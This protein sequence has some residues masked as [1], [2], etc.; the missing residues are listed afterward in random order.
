MKRLFDTMENKEI[1]IN[2]LAIDSFQI[3]L[4]FL[5]EKDV[6]SFLKS[7][8][9]CKKWNKMIMELIKKHSQMSLQDCFY[10]GNIIGIVNHIMKLKQVGKLMDEMIYDLIYLNHYAKL[11][12]FNFITRF[13]CNLDD[14]FSFAL[15][16]NYTE[17]DLF[18]FYF[19][20]NGD[21]F[22]EKMEELN[23]N[24]IIELHKRFKEDTENIGK[25]KRISSWKNYTKTIKSSKIIDQSFIIKN[26]SSLSFSNPLLEEEEIWE[27][28]LPFLH[29]NGLLTKQKIIEWFNKWSKE[30]T[31]EDNSNIKDSN[32]TENFPEMATFNYHDRELRQ[33]EVK[34]ITL[35]SSLDEGYVEDLNIKAIVKDYIYIPIIYKKYESLINNMILEIS[36][37]ED[38][39]R[40]DKFTNIDIILNLQI[41]TNKIQGLLDWFNIFDT[42]ILWQYKE[43]LYDSE[44]IFPFNRWNKNVRRFI[45]LCDNT[46]FIDK[47]FFIDIV[48]YRLHK[49]MILILQKRTIPFLKQNEYNIDETLF[50]KM[51]LEGSLKDEILDEIFV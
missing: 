9:V 50:L 29:L 37:L 30:N 14:I 6:F 39:I 10:Y 15:S 8:I 4:K 7:R 34:I 3:I 12:N 20:M 27:S 48:E 42:D 49:L 32:I 16:F 40:R 11:V 22:I 13:F 24:S 5:C 35:L 28:V 19:H 26:F 47:T 45:E 21:K 33:I 41:K 2:H 36:T 17:T 18:R 43:D 31:I 1:M 46:N 51:L 23:P 38:I 25:K 44:C